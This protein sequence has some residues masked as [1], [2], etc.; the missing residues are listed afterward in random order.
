MFNNRK[1]QSFYDGANSSGDSSR[2]GMHTSHSLQEF[3]QM[4][5]SLEESER[6]IYK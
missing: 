2:S 4:R 1:Y 5:E 3:S 6:G